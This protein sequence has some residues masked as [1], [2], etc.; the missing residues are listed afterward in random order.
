MKNALNL[1]VLVG[2]ATLFFAP[3]AAYCHDSPQGIFE[4]ANQYYKDEDFEKAKVA[5]QALVDSGFKNVALF[6]NLGNA[7]FRTG[8]LGEAMLYYHKAKKLDPN[9]DAIDHNIALAEQQL[10]DKIE[11]LPRGFFADFKM[12]LSSAPAGLI[13]WLALVFG[14][15]TLIFGYLFLF[16]EKRVLGFSG[17]LI[18][19]TLSI[20]LFVYSQWISNHKTRIKEGVILSQSTYVKSGPTGQQSDLFILHEGTHFKILAKSGEWLEI[21]IADGKRGWV[22]KSDVAEI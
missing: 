20:V 22:S 2:I 3:F 5:Y 12:W 7:Y 17:M 16:T 1:A 9:D 15:S 4:E 11:P 21:R 14:L 6:F 19:I 18:G 13:G 8:N 10:V